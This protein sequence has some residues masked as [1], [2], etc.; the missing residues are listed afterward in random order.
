ME[1]LVGRVP[2]GARRIE[3][4]SR[5]RVVS[6][7]S[8]RDLLDRRVPSAT[9]LCTGAHSLVHQAVVSI[10]M[11]QSKS[12]AGWAAPFE[13]DCPQVDRNIISGDARSRIRQVCGYF[14]GELSYFSYEYAVW[15]KGREVILAKVWT[16]AQSVRHSTFDEEGKTTAERVLADLTCQ[17]DVVRTNS[18][19]VKLAVSYLN[20][21]P[22][23]Q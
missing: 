18:D 6:I 7:R 1:F 12:G 3:T 11:A 2:G 13:E 4:T 16:E 23:G 19:A 17:A 15:L 8:L 9:R 20:T 14:N 5:G 21:Y 10:L 22:E